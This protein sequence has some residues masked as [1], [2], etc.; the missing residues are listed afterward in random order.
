V[1]AIGTG[2]TAAATGDTALMTEITA[3]GGA[4]VAA[5]MTQTTTTY[6]NDTAKFVAVWTASSALAPVEA[7][8]FDSTT[9]AG[10]HLLAHQVF[11]VVNMS[12]GDS[13]TITWTVQS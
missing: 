9:V 7:G 2:A 11:S 1:V 5:T 12:I 4:R 13:L 8:I 10:S 6:T 3:G